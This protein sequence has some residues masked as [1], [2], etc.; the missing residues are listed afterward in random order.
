MPRCTIHEL[1]IVSV[2]Y[3]QKSM[4]GNNMEV[5]RTP[6]GTEYCIPRYARRRMEQRNIRQ[7][8]LEDALDTY[9]RKDYDRKGNERLYRRLPDGVILEVIVAK[10]SK[11]L[12]IITIHRLNKA[13]GKY[14]IRI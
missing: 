4:G 6:K 7:S 12:I 11:P 5:Y 2:Q 8:V 13:G 9:D 3:L 10:E 14:G 1:E